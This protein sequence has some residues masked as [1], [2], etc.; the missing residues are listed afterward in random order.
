MTRK[1]SATSSPLQK[2]R[3]AVYT[4]KSSEEG[5]E[6]E[7]NSLEAQALTADRDEYEPYRYTAIPHRAYSGLFK[8]VPA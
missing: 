2:L 4:R 5:L 7:F 3:C 8:S 6:T 1:Q